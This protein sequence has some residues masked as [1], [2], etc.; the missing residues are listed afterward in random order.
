MSDAASSHL[1]VLVIIL[2]FNEYEDTLGCL[3]S[4]SGLR[5]EE[6]DVVVC[7]NGSRTEIAAQLRTNLKK[8]HPTVCLLRSNTNLG[9]AGG[10]TF[11]L[12]TVGLVRYSHVLLL[13]NDT[14]SSPRDL[15]LLFD[16]AAARGSAIA[17][18]TVTYFD[19]PNVVWQ[20]GGTLLTW[21]SQLSVPGKNHSLDSIEPVVKAVDYISGCAMLVSRRFIEAH[22]FLDPS[23]FYGVE[24]IDY[25]TLAVKNGCSVDYFPKPVVAH[26]VSRTSGGWHSRFSAWHSIWGKG[27]FIWKH[28]RGL[29]W[30]TSV[31][32]Q[33]LVVIPAK[34]QRCPDC[35]LGDIWHLYRAF[36]MGLGGAKQDAATS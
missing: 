24:D 19:Q 30:V 23:Y 32:F 11:V 17:G 3:D 13:N 15:K 31:M 12:D 36:F 22:G 26:R 8:Y 7:D 29:K 27:R 28:V 5:Q 21:L 35:Q 10:N 14:V 1:K 2:A 9:F 18:P 25:C 16:G 4:L 20:G 34:W 6:F 33:V